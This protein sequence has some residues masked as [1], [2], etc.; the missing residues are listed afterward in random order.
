MTVAAI[1]M[2]GATVVTGMDAPLVLEPAVH[3]L[4]LVT[5]AREVAVVSRHLTNGF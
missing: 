2:A 5:L 1:R 4:D 3:V